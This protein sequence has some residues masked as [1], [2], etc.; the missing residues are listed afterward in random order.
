MD[1]VWVD[2]SFYLHYSILKK[3]SSLMALAERHDIRIVCTLEQ[4]DF[5]IF[6]PNHI[7][8]LELLP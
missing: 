2:S 1:K 8:R 3:I 4:R 6:R 5:A 7:E